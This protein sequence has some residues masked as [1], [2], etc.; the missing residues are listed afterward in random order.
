MANSVKQYAVDNPIKT[1]A[2]VAGAAAVPLV[3][4]Y[5]LQKKHEKKKSAIQGNEV[6]GQLVPA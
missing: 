3:L 4:A 6:T 5:L 1:T 2:G